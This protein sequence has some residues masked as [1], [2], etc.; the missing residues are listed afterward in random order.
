MKS[1]LSLVAIF[2]YF[3]LG[4][5]CLETAPGQNSESDS[6]TDEEAPG[7]QRASPVDFQIYD[8]QTRKPVVYL[9]GGKF[10]VE[11]SNQSTADLWFANMDAK[12]DAENHHFQLLFRPG[13]FIELTVSEET[14]ATKS[15]NEGPKLWELSEPVVNSD[16]TVSVFVCYKDATS[17]WPANQSKTLTLRYVTDLSNGPRASVV[18]MRLGDIGFT[19]DPHS[20]S[21]FHRRKVIDFTHREK[22]SAE[23]PNVEPPISK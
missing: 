9:E 11:W 13:S 12:P 5:L 18:E 16:K 8:G 6:V 20:L 7:F 22:S 2:L 14:D 21:G 1:N 4:N 17:P 19:S 3:G 15:S 10:T 23:S